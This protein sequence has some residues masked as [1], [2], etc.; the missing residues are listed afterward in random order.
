[1]RTV[2]VLAKRRAMDSRNAR[3]LGRQRCSEHFPEGPR[4]VA[5]SMSKITP[6]PFDVEVSVVRPFSF[7]EMTISRSRDEMTNSRPGG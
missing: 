3:K 4:F 7:R 1:M 5:R 6:F 2:W